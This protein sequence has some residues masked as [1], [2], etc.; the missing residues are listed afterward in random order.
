MGVLDHEQDGTAPADAAQDVGDRGVEPV[1]SGVGVRGRRA[2]QLADPRGEGGR[3]ARELARRHAGDVAELCGVDAAREVVEGLD[4]RPVG[5]AYHR[6]AGAVE[7][8]RAGGCR[9]AGE[10]AHEAALAGARLAAQ[11]HDAAALARRPRQH[12]AQRLELGRPADER[13]GRR[14]AERPGQSVSGDGQI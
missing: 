4:E 6:V 5:R 3:E 14:K 11:E 1:A 7:H 8:Q 12:R 10:L 9:L 2:R 13:E